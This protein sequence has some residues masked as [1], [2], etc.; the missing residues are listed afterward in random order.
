[1]D[2]I[3]CAKLPV[4][5]ILCTQRTRLT[6]DFIRTQLECWQLLL[7]P[8]PPPIRRRPTPGFRVQFG[9]TSP[10]FSR[11]PLT[12]IY[13]QSY[14][15]HARRCGCHRLSSSVVR[16][17]APSLCQYLNANVTADYFGTI[18][19]LYV[20]IYVGTF[21]QLERSF[22]DRCVRA[23]RITVVRQTYNSYTQSIEQPK[24]VTAS[25]KNLRALLS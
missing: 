14:R 16:G 9:R 23:M 5:Y 13:I 22:R 10:I 18:G 2:A 21:G 19:T 24:T 20:Y 8:P 15:A 11:F 3:A 7:N 1:M 12:R 25:A 17:Q 4:G 6:V